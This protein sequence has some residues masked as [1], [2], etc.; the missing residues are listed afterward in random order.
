A[1]G[2]FFR[3]VGFSGQVVLCGRNPHERLP[4]PVTAKLSQLFYERLGEQVANELVDWFNAV[5]A[6]Y[7]GD[8]RELNELNARIDRVVAEMEARL[9]RGLKEQTRWLLLAWGTV[10]AG[11]IAL[12]ARG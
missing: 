1:R 4:M 6:T 9:E 10:L 2:A 12:L 3:L 11:V 5:D 7:R 8:L